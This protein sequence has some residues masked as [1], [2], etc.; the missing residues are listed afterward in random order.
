[1]PAERASQR[2][3]S[4]RI[5]DFGAPGYR[6]NGHSAAQRFRHGYQVRLDSE[7]FAGEPFPGAA[8]ARLHLIR[9]KQDAVLA[10]SLL[11]N[12]EIIS[13]RHN[14][15]AFAQNRFGNDRCH[16]LRRDL[17]LE[18]IFKVVGKALRVRAAP[19][20][21]RIREGNAINV[22]GKW[23]KSSLV[24]MRLAGERHSQQCASVKSILKANYRRPL[25]VSAR[26]FDRVLD[27][28]R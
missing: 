6:G 23:L 25:G 14:E 21:I 8:K 17:A 19:R 9:N 5:H 10:A 15:A 24:R 28:L 7:M 11:Q 22:A 13:R 3:G 18:R 27:G 20:T 4:W 16:R 2:S 1:M 26:D 12:L